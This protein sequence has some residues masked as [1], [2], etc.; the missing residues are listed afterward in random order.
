MFW[1]EILVGVD[2]VESREW[3]LEIILCRV[4]LFEELVFLGLLILVIWDGGFGRLWGFVV[5]YFFLG[6][7]V[8]LGFGVK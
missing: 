1:F 3:S 2:L 6:F 7:V 5:F 8:I 4:E